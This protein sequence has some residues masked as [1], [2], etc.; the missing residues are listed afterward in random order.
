MKILFTRNK[1]T[2]L[3]PSSLGCAS[4]SDV[5][6]CYK[7]C[8]GMTEWRT[9]ITLYIYRYKILLY[10][11]P[12]QTLHLLVSLQY[13]WWYGLTSPCW[14]PRSRRQRSWW[15]WW[16]TDWVKETCNAS[17]PVSVTP[18]LK[19]LQLKTIH[20]TLIMHGGLLEIWNFQTFIFI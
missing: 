11:D 14:G 10:W 19:N 2:L 17:L 18:C 4:H 12:L 7:F 3:C 16:A 20:L 1:G 8:D 6:G 5:L 15:P 13:P 9:N